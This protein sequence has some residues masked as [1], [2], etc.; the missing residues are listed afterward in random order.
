[1][2]TREG[3]RAQR[4]LTSR[5]QGKQYAAQRHDNRGQAPAGV[6][7]DGIP[8]PGSD[9]GQDVYYRGSNPIPER[10]AANTHAVSFKI[11]NDMGVES[12]TRG[13]IFAHGHRFGGH[14]LYVKDGT[15]NYA[16]N[17]RHRFGAG[18]SLPPPGRHII[19]V[20][21]VKEGIEST[22]KARHRNALCRWQSDRE[23]ADPNDVPALLVL[24]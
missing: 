10:S 8:G 13:V 16:Y 21:F 24:R 19:G 11:L 18:A 9:G 14:A 4:A 5:G 17:P 12:A 3:G 20:D 15:V 1:M 6:P 22:A 7:T 23:Q 2:S